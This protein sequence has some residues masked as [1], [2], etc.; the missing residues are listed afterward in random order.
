MN[1]LY[2]GS[3]VAVSANG[4]EE[5]LITEG[6]LWRLNGLTLDWA[7]PE[8]VVRIIVVLVLYIVRLLFHQNVV[9]FEDDDDEERRTG[10]V[11]EAL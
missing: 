2:E 9:L 1:S 10:K 11:E 6:R 5:S 3:K 7:V 4:S 8:L